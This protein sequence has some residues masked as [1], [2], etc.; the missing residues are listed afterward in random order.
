MACR[1][2]FAAVLVTLTLGCDRPDR[3]PLTVVTPTGVVT[4][5]TEPTIVVPVTGLTGSVVVITGG[6]LFTPT[7]LPLDSLTVPRGSTVTFINNDNRPHVL[8]IAGT[9]A[10]GSV[11]PGERVSVV[12]P[13][14]GVFPFTVRPSFVVSIFVV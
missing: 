13:T 9:V 8:P 1:L 3:T 4:T 2:M 11:Q 14:A 5:I 6:S 7:G 10:P 12:F